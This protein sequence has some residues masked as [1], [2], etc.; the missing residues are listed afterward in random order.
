MGGRVGRCQPQYK[1]ASSDTFW[2]SFFYAFKLKLNVFFKSEINFGSG[3]KSRRNKKQTPPDDC[4][5]KLKCQN[6]PNIKNMIPYQ[7]KIFGEF[8]FSFKGKSL[9][10]RQGYL[11]FFDSTLV[12]RK[13]FELVIF[14]RGFSTLLR[15]KATHFKYHSS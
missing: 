1:L 3:R 2:W 5:P 13:N 7:K 6:N 11:D 8:Q 9:D 14:I 12:R 10:F 15:N 4:S